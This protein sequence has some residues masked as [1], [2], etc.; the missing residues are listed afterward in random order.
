MNFSS[1]KHWHSKSLHMGTGKVVP[2]HTMKAYRGAQKCNS[3]HSKTSALDR[4]MWR[5]PRLVS[6]THENKPR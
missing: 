4:G 3:T 6:F 2:V 5:A 1:N